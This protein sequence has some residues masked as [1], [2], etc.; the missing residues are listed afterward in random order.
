MTNNER[1]TGSIMVSLVIRPLPWTLI[2][3]TEHCLDFLRQAAMCHGDV[4]LVTYQWSP[5][6][7]IPVANATIHECVDW[8]A[9]DKWTK[10]RTVDMMKP[11]WLIHPTKGTLIFLLPFLYSPIPNSIYLSD[12]SGINCSK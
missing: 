2:R 9:I 10:E 12:K 4:G 6:N 3:N 7:L 11:G 5:D 1:L 8:T